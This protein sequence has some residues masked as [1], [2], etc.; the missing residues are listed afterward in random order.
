MGAYVDVSD[1][2]VDMLEFMGYIVVSEDNDFILVNHKG[3]EQILSKD[4]PRYLHVEDGND[5]DVF[6]KRKAYKAPPSV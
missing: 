6:R 5:A 1:I 4:P 3:D 2:P